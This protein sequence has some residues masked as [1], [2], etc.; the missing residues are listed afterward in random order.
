M[1]RQKKVPRSGYWTPRHD[2]TQNLIDALRIEN[3]S[4]LPGEVP[5]VSASASE[6]IESGNRY[7]GVDPELAVALYRKALALDASNTTARQSLANN[8][9][10]LDRPKEVVDVLNNPKDSR[11]HLLLALAYWKLKKMNV[12]SEL[13]AGLKLALK[14]PQ[15][16][17][18]AATLFEDLG[19]YDGAA[20]T[21]QKTDDWRQETVDPDQRGPSARSCPL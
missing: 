14:D 1:F 4:A 17:E 2:L 3:G 5:S 11:D 12:R 15:Y 10:N 8:L 16:Y 21:R 6:Y 7:Q 9:L 20:T 13:K 19:D 18:R